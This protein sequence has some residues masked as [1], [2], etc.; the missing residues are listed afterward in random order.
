MADDILQRIVETKKEEVQR[1]PA[2]EGELRDRL[3]DAP[4]P[5]NLKKAFLQDGAVAVMAE[6]KRRSPGGGEIRPGLDPVALGRSYEEAGAS[7]ISVLTD[8][9]YFGGGLD[10]LIRVR[11]AV[12]VPVFRKDFIVHPL[13][14]LEARVAGADGALLIAR[15][16]TSDE[17][18]DLHAQ[19]LEL[20]LTPLVEVHQREELEGALAAGARLIGINNRNLRTFRTSLEVTLDL[21]P[22]LPPEAVVVSES[23]IRTPHDVDR[24][25]SAGV[26]GVLVGESLLRAP[27][28]GEALR[29]LVDR[30]R[31]P[32]EGFRG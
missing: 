20:G 12:E 26:H 3:G 6:I 31:T 24:L 1:L 2:R 10:D 8:R 32:R 28:P 11:E 23:G 13:Q 30:K 18:R 27:D 15:I 21:L 19:A 29:A 22:H 4:A 9:T 7:A 16:L 17:L 5:R 25:G 14:L